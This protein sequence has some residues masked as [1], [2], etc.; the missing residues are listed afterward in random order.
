M[1]R[2]QTDQPNILVMDHNGNG[3][4]PEILRA[5]ANEINENIQKMKEAILKVNTLAD[6]FGSSKK[7]DEEIIL[8]IEL[9][10][11]RYEYLAKLIEKGQTE[12]EDTLTLA[13]IRK[14]LE[15]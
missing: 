4:T 7:I 2:R 11:R 3:L 9:V 12:K 15:E 14:L 10:P 8:Q 1:K 13:A 5:S 6:L